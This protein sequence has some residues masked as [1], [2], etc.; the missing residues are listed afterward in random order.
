MYTDSGSDEWKI[1]LGVCLGIPLAA[2][3][4]VNIFCLVRYKRRRAKNVIL[5]DYVSE[6]GSYPTMANLFG[7]PGASMFGKK[8]AWNYNE[9]ISSMPDLHRNEDDR[10][11][12]FYRGLAGDREFTIKRPQVDL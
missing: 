2:I 10:F 5:D 11:S 7:L 4:A 3:I 6:S 9:S 8:A 1:I 12:Q